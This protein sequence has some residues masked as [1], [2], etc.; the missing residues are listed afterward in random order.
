MS[1]QFVQKQMYTKN[2]MF[3]LW[4]IANQNVFAAVD[5]C[6]VVFRTNSLLLISAFEHCE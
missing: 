4:I 2:I 1:R 5:V 3:W 6:E